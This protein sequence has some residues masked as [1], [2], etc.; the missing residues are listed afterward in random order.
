[1]EGYVVGAIK[2]LVPVF[3]GMKYGYECGMQAS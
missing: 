1:M 3:G 2:R